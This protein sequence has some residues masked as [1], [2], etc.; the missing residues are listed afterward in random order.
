[1]YPLPGNVR[2]VLSPAI[3]LQCRETCHNMYVYKNT[4]CEI[5]L[6]LKFYAMAIGIHCQSKIAELKIEDSVFFL[7]KVK[8]LNYVPK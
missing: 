3:A 1:M 5:F 6:Y 2:L 7:L 4:H 8:G